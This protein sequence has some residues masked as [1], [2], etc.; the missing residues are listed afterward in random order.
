MKQAT[1]DVKN[2]FEHRFKEMRD[3]NSHVT[4]HLKE[5][6]NTLRV[7]VLSS[8]KEIKKVCHT[9]FD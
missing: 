6:F 1:D 5:N 4:K 3:G 8:I 7:K 2:T 9:Q